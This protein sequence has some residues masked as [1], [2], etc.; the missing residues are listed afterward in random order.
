MQTMEKN[1]GLILPEFQKFLISRGL[2]AENSVPYFALWV[3]RFQDFCA[4]SSRDAGDGLKDFLVYPCCFQNPGLQAGD[5]SKICWIPC[6]PAG[7]DLNTDFSKDA[8]KSGFTSQ[9]R[10]MRGENEQK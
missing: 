9:T 6:L 3:K 5:E 10:R 7:R 2:A 1:V 4:N 8:S